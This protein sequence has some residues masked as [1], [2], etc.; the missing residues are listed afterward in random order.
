[1]K[2]LDVTND[3]SV[4]TC[5]AETIK[6][7]GRIDVLVNNAGFGARK[8][9]EQVLQG[10][11]ISLSLMLGGFVLHQDVSIPGWSYGS[12]HILWS[13]GYSLENT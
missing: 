11:V 5:V 10:R 9:T 2:E 12:L 3:S 8:N 7:H 13:E 6:E 4:H 1:M